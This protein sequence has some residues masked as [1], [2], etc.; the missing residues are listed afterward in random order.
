MFDISQAQLDRLNSDA[1]ARGEQPIDLLSWHLASLPPDAD[2]AAVIAA[3]LARPEVQYAY[4]H[5]TVVPPPPNSDNLDGQ[6]AAPYSVPGSSLVFSLSQE[7]DSLHG[8][9]SFA[10]EAGRQGTLEVLGSYRRPTVNLTLI[11]DFGQRLFFEG[12][13]QDSRMVGTLTDS[14]GRT[15]AGAFI[16]H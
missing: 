3:L 13:V 5:S 4:P 7:A 6:W 16:R 12:H 9:G 2:T 1:R 15:S 8:G 14:A 11:Y 10:I